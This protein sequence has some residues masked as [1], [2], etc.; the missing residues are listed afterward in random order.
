MVD[1][2]R[3]WKKLRS[4]LG[5]DGERLQGFSE[6]ADEYFQSYVIGHNRAPVF[7][8]SRLGILKRH[9]SNTPIDSI[10]AYKVDKYIT[11]RKHGGASVSTIN[12]DLA[13]LLHMYQWALSRGYLTENP[14]IGVKKLKEAEWVGERPDESTINAI[15]SNL[16]VAV[17]PVF[18]FLRETGCR[19]GE[20]TTLTWGQVNYA[21]AYVTFRQTKNGRARQVPL[22]SA[23]LSALSAMP[24]H[25]ATVF[26]HPGTL[27]PWD[28][29][30]IMKPWAR[31]RKKANSALRIHDLR[32]DYAIRLAEA[33]CA[34]H[35]ISEVLG[36]SSVEFT[37]KRYARYS[38]E[39]ASRAVLLVLETIAV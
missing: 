23:A 15:F 3:V 33:S 11:A 36:H 29:W 5:L 37:R 6:V 14:L 38:P 34:M 12:R 21:N 31:A 17:I 24:R 13:V 26:Y 4:E 19:S 1:E 25:G 35:F 39:S 2:K 20:A 28:K 10:S 18:T 32:H 7:K 16:P 9:F 22:T 8:Q 27:K 30:S